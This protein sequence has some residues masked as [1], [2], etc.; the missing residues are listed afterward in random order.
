MDDKMK[1][2][3]DYIVDAMDPE[4]VCSEPEL[5]I[6]LVKYMKSEMDRRKKVIQT[7]QEVIED[8]L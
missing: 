1:Y 8:I 2:T 5:F 3:L 6:E 4:W 7:L